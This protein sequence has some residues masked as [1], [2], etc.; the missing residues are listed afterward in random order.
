[1][2]NCDSC[3]KEIK[4]KSYPIVDENFRKQKGLRQCESCYSI[5]CGGDEND[6]IK[7]P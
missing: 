7:E 2:N 3:G 6:K 4:G 5:Q 1:M